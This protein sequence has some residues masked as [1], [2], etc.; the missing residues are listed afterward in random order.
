[1]DQ[2]REWL[3]DHSERYRQRAMQRR[4]VIRWN[5]AGSRLLL[6][7]I[8]IVSIP[9]GALILISAVLNWGK[10]GM[11]SQAAVATGCLIAFNGFAWLMDWFIRQMAPPA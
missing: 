4:R 1:M 8:R 9:V 5:V 2:E 6:R 10:P 11:A 7:A 3:E